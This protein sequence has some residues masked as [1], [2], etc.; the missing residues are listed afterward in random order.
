MNQRK[1]G[2]GPIDNG[3]ERKLGR[4]MINTRCAGAETFTLPLL[5]LCTHNTMQLLLK[6][7]DARVCVRIHYS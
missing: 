3:Y 2:A 6:R 5:V 1:L 7:A 4:L